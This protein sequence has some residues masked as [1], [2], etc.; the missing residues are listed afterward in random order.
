[1]Y[2]CLT[3]RSP[4]AIAPAICTIVASLD[5]AFDREVQGQ[6]L[7]VTAWKFG[8]G[9]GGAIAQNSTLNLHPHHDSGPP[10]LGG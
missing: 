5:W 6:F 4:K 1:L 8:V 2:A 7:T 9:K 10:K 3:R